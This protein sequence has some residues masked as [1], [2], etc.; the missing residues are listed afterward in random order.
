M[1]A[2]DAKAHLKLHVHLMEARL[3]ITWHARVIVLNS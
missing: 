1:R 2:V 3:R